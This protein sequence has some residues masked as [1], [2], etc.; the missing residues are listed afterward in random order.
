MTYPDETTSAQLYLGRDWPTALALG[1]RR[2]RSATRALRFAF[3]HAAPVS[4]RGARL[5]IA[6]R[7]FAGEDLA[8]LNR[9]RIAQPA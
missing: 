9:L 1:P 3:E 4:L 6:G 7:A 8:R 2:F 5:L